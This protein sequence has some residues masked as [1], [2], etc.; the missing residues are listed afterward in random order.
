MS[1]TCNF[2][3]EEAAISSE[4]ANQWTHAVGWG[5]SLIGGAL[6]L[7]AVADCGDTWRACGCV[8]YAAALIG[9]YAASTLS[10]AVTDVLWRNRFRMLDQICIFLL[11]VGT[12]TAYAM[13]YARDGWLGNMLAIMWGIALL[14]IVA[15]V[16]SGDQSVS[17]T[18][19][20]ALGWIPILALGRILD[21]TGLA[22]TSLAIGGG[23]VYTAGTW[24][25][26]NDHKHPHFHAVWHCFTMLGSLIHFVYV[27]QYVAMLPVG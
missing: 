1:T 6:L 9:V 7:R 27:Y 17:F 14:G 3:H 13:T 8:V 18:W 12:Y 25:L 16:R 21:T 11:V 24:F 15:R 5:L 19:Y 4:A 10:H 22:G 20:V 26:V 23:V 2:A